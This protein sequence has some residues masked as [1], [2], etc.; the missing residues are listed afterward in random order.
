MKTASERGSNQKPLT[1]LTVRVIIIIIIYE[2]YETNT[3]WQEKKSHSRRV[4]LDFFRP[5]NASITV[6]SFMNKIIILA[7]IIIIIRYGYKK[8]IE[9]YCVSLA[10]K[11]IGFNLSAIEQTSISGKEQKKYTTIFACKSSRKSLLPHR[12]HTFVFYLILCV[13]N[14][15]KCYVY[16]IIKNYF[17]AAAASS[18]YVFNLL[19]IL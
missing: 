11:T 15:T 9:W 14:A 13:L 16:I 5:H 8:N 1:T 10:A 7:K 3:L 2:R 18:P 12:M 4:R 19:Q 17:D 6:R